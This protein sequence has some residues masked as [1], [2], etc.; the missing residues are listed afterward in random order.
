M[1]TPGG[2]RTRTWRRFKRPV[3]AGWTTGAGREE[4]TAR[5]DTD[6]D[7]P[8]PLCDR[9]ST[10]HT[11]R[12]PV[13]PAERATV[14]TALGV[15]EFRALLA[16]SALSMAG[17]QVARIAVALL[18]Y[19]RSGSAFAAA[20]TYA[21]SYLTWLFGGP[22][23]TALADRLPRR[24]LMV[25]C[26][27]LR[28]ALVCVL[29]VP[30]V[31]LSVVFGVLLLVGLL[32]PPYD[33]AKSAVLPDVL[34]G[35]LYVVGN[36]LQ[37]TV[38]Q[39]ANVAGFLLGGAVVA[40]TSVHGAL[41]IDAASFVLSALLLAA[42]AERPLPERQDASLLTDAV[43]GFRLVARRRPLRRLLAYGLL[44]AVV[45][46]TPEGMAVPVARE[47]GGGPL[48]A[49][50]L[51]AAVPAGFLVGSFLLLRVPPARRTALL[52][53]LV[54]LSAAALL[55]TP[56]LSSVASVAT[57]WAV[58]GAGS[59]L[60]IIANAAYMQAVPAELRGRAFGVADTL[61][62]A[63]Q[64]VVLL[65]VGALAERLDPLGA[66][67]VAGVGA[68]GGLGLL[69]CGRGAWTPRPAVEVSG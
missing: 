11:A 33:A 36:A 64:G 60:G 46:V 22:V 26:D 63:L 62:M 42:V 35:D 17:D 5:H 68:L 59:A 4:V 24:R 20:A 2:I 18:V 52:P 56:L 32:S 15:R 45:M 25:V 16:S 21:L 61:L 6:T 43:E 19:R 23:L 38:F 13:V 31:P 9:P 14:R 55:V 41:A 51:T 30:H 3:S 8:T 10:R 29:L 28:A 1:R 34:P 54:V 69:T 47:L 67:A 49:G 27:L 7:L 48:A 53:G 37:N 44:G 65:A 39:A 12:V 58:A 40:V 66:V 50:V 57:A